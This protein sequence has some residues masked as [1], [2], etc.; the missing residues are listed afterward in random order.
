MNTVMFPDLLQVLACP[1]CT[2]HPLQV[3]RAASS[4]EDT[5]WLVCALCHRTYPIRNGVPALL[6]DDLSPTLQAGKGWR[7]WRRKLDN[8]LA[9]R[10]ERART[11]ST[12]TAQCAAVGLALHKRLAEL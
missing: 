12:Q 8:F 11:S 5:R 1:E 10:E 2:Y 6:P 4:D 7:T 9:W 3:Q